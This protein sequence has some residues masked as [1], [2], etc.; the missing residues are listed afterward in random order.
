MRHLKLFSLL[1][2][3]SLALFV[4]GCG[5]GNS[6]GHTTQTI[7]FANPGTQTVGVPLTL[8]AEASS[9][10]AVTFTSATPGVCTVSATTATFVTAGICTIDAGQTGNSTYAAASQVTQSF[11]VN[12]AIGPNTTIYIAG[13]AIPAVNPPNGVELSRGMEAYLRQPDCH[14]DGP[15]DAQRH[16]KLAS[17]RDRGIG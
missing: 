6:I 7:T 4:S 16:D 10:A 8:S 1:S 2:V 3:T 17:Q 13:S 15:I 12:P 14:S 9:D 11:T 5:G